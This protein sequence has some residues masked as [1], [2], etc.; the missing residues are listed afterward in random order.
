MESYWI[1][2][3]IAAALALTGMLGLAWR[4]RV[5][6]AKRWLTALDAYADRQ[7]AQER[8]GKT[9]KED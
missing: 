5:R 3:V 9:L 7:I 4:L 8:R 1:G 2:L 6:A